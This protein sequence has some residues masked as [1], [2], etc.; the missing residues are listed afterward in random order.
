MAVD[1]QRAYT[2]RAQATLGWSIHRN[3]SSTRVEA[4]NPQHDWRQGGALP[5]T[6]T[7]LA[8]ERTREGNESCDYVRCVGHSESETILPHQFACAINCK[9]ENPL[10]PSI[11]ADRQILVM[12]TR[13]LK[14]AIRRGDNAE[15]CKVLYQD[16][17]WTTSS[18]PS[19]DHGRLCVDI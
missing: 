4:G 19:S 12:S 17:A 14:E 13:K 5:I 7:T 11:L 15:T 9:L 8:T 16:H 18:N 2:T 10:K 6:R 3:G 1:K